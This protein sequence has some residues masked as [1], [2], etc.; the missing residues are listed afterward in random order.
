V[1][2]PQM[3]AVEVLSGQVTIAME[4]VTEIWPLVH[5]HVQPQ[6]C[7]NR[8]SHLPGVYKWLCFRLKER[9]LN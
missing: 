6:H 4:T 1:D 5:L 2:T 3:V 7:I 9:N 8:L